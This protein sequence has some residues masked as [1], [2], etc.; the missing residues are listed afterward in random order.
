MSKEDPSF[1][2]GYCATFTGKMIVPDDPKPEDIDI[3]D[4]AVGLSQQCRYSGQVWPFYSVAE[5]SILVSQLVGQRADDK[6][7]ALRALMHDS[8]EFILNDMVRPVKRKVKGY[9]VLED[10]VMRAIDTKFDLRYSKVNWT[11]IKYYDDLITIT[12][13]RKLMRRLPVSV[14]GRGVPESEV[15]NI[16]FKCMPPPE[17]ALAFLSTF[18]S[19]SGTSPTQS[20]FE[21]IRYLQKGY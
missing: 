5:H 18:F 21:D 13:R 10:K 20:Q 11:V 3:I 15:P 12:E 16:N 19:L 6:R 2:N 1:I 17:A 9:D 4:I 8:P 14:Y 7:Y